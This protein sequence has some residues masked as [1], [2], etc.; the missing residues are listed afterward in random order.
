MSDT[1]SAPLVLNVKEALQ[2]AMQLHQDGRL[3]EAEHVYQEVLKWDPG[4]SSALHCLGILMVQV[5]Q[6][7]DAI[8][9]I[10][11]A[12]ANC[13][14]NPQMH[15]H[16]GEAFRMMGRNED[17]MK[18][19]EH[20]LSLDPDCVEVLNNVGVALSL[21]GRQDEALD[22]LN[23]AISIAPDYA[24]AWNNKGVVLESMGQLDK[25]VSCY[26]EAV[27]NKQ[28]YEDA[29]TA[30]VSALRRLGTNSQWKKQLK[31]EMDEALAKYE[32]LVEKYPDLAEPHNV[33]GVLL[34]ERSRFEEGMAYYRRR[35]LTN[36]VC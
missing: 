13:P 17:A 14:D 24:E 26:A 29:Q 32:K 25:A 31:E 10:R 11:K 5:G 8:A 19:Y 2:L 15:N 21:L 12:L 4:N 16:L 34:C 36:A 22:Q 6:P 23:K 33:L 28:N 1:S 35:A 9:L 3:D 7:E 20:A 30:F 18:E 27:K